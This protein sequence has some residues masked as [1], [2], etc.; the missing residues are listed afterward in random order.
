MAALTTPAYKYML[1]IV[2]LMLCTMFYTYYTCVS[3]SNCPAL[4]KFPTISNT[5]DDPPGNYISRFVLSIVA[6]NFALIHYALWLPEQGNMKCYKTGLALGVFSSFCLS[7]VGAICDSDSDPQCLGNN[8]IH[9]TFAVCFFVIYDGIMVV[10]S[11]KG[12]KLGATLVHKACAGA[13]LLLKVRWLPLG[14]APGLLGDETLLAVFEWCD[15]FFIMLWTYFWLKAHR[16]TWSVWLQQA[17]P[18]APA[19][20]TLSVHDTTVAAVCIFVREAGRKT[21]CGWTF[22]PAVVLARPYPCSYASC[23]RTVTATD[24]PGTPCCA[25][26]SV[27]TLSKAAVAW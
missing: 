15:V 13:S 24:R 17:A 3:N 1:V 25:M 2:A 6:T 23:P 21:D 11:L 10:L 18:A 27:T 20:V 14:A 9:S 7:W 19:P 5:F 26:K 8:T 12:T 22:V 4:P 16:P